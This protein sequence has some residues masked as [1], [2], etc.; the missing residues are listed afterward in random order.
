MTQLN[1]WGMAWWAPT[2]KKADSYK[3]PEKCV[4]CG[5][6]IEDDDYFHAGYDEHRIYA[7]TCDNFQCFKWL[8]WQVRKRRRDFLK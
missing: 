7:E 3:P 5:T 4:F 8:K 1:N 2:K 6:K